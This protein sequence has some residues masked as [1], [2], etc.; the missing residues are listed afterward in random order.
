MRTRNK[1]GV[2][3][4]SVEIKNPVKVQIPDPSGTEPEAK[5]LLG[6]NFENRRYV[7]GETVLSYWSRN[8]CAILKRLKRR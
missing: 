7:G 5:L 4:R 8:A 6:Q 1:G 2:D 3:Q